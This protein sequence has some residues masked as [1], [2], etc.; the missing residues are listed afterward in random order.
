MRLTKL[1][2]Q[3]AYVNWNGKSLVLKMDTDGT[4]TPCSKETFLDDNCNILV[5]F[6]PGFFMPQGTWWFIG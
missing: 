3:Y 2:E 5:Q 1:N 4:F 6:S